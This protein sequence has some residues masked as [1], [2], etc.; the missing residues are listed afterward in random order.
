MSTWARP[1]WLSHSVPRSSSGLRMR[2]ASRK[3]RSAAA[4]SPRL[5]LDPRAGVVHTGESPCVTGLGEELAR[6]V[7][8]GRCLDEATPQEV[9]LGLRGQRPADHVDVAALLGELERLARELRA[10]I[11]V[12]PRDGDRGELLGRARLQVLAADLARD[13]ERAGRPSARRRR[14]RPATSRCARECSAPRSGPPACPPRA[15]RGPARRARGRAA[16]R[17]RAGARRRQAR[18]APAPRAVSSPSATASANTASISAAC[19]GKSASLPAALA[20]R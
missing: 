9:D 12:E 1:R 15:A 20:A 8:P 5:P 6:A 18:P 7:E 11:E 4:R 13:L 10:A 17:R 2:I 16:G 19:A 14:G 3:R